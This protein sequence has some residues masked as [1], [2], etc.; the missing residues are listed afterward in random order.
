[1]KKRN[2]NDTKLSLEKVSI[3]KLNC[4]SSIKG[5]NN[6][7]NTTLRYLKTGDSIGDPGSDRFM[8]TINSIK[9]QN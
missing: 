9:V 7:Y 2:Q 6:N 3:A 4:S 5:G 8:D 1:M